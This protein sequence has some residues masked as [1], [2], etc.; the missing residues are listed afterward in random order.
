MSQTHLAPY[1]ESECVQSLKA[2]SPS[3]NISWSVVYAAGLSSCSSSSSL[4]R[5]LW[6]LRRGFS[7]SATS[8]RM[9]QGAAESVAPTNWVSNGEYGNTAPLVWVLLGNRVLLSHLVVRIMRVEFAV[10]MCGEHQ[11]HGSLRILRRNNIR[12]PFRTIRCL[13]GECILLHIPIQ[14]TQCG[15]NIVTNEGVVC[16]VRC[17]FP[18][19]G[20]SAKL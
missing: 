13:I 16:S 6:L 20:V 9:A 11:L 7:A 17:K 2:S 3:K 12:E 1:I 10:K 4:S 8:R 15:N 14:R 19:S 5:A 18:L